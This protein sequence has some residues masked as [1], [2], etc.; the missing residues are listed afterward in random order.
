MGTLA[1][2]AN[3]PVTDL[4][5]TG[6]AALTTVLALLAIGLLGG[7]ALASVAH[8]AAACA[9]HGAIKG[10]ASCEG[11]KSAGQA[12]TSANVVR[13]YHDCI[14]SYQRYKDLRGRRQRYHGGG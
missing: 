4:L 7:I 8:R 6:T 9:R 2:T 14:R 12:K 13:N 11:R 1:L 10:A 5:L 3:F